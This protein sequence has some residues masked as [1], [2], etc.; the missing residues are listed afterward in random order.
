MLLSTS[1]TP[2]DLWDALPAAWCSEEVLPSLLLLYE[3]P[4]AEQRCV[5]N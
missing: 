4:P 2:Q 3:H 1:Q 5:M